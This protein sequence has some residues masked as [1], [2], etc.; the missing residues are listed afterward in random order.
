MNNI[1]KFKEIDLIKKKP[2]ICIYEEHIPEIFKKC[3]V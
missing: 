2:N 1:F 3:E